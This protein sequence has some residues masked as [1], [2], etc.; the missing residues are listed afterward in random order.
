VEPN[1]RPTNGRCH[2]PSTTCATCRCA[3]QHATKSNR[4]EHSPPPSVGHRH[5]TAVLPEKPSDRDRQYASIYNYQISAVS[6]THLSISAKAKRDSRSLP[7]AKRTGAWKTEKPP[8]THTK[9]FTLVQAWPVIAYRGGPR[10]TTPKDT[11]RSS[12]LTRC[13]L[14]QGRS[15]RADALCNIHAFAIDNLPTADRIR[16]FV[17]RRGYLFPKKRTMMP[18][19]LIVWFG[20]FY[21]DPGRPR[22]PRLM[23]ISLAWS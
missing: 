9:P 4:P 3:Q 20:A 18:L 10:P 23:A 21:P 19:S 15:L 7:Q 13:L 8:K 17:R 11:L 16:R 2:L 5:A 1:P 14:R 12:H 22:K 6:S